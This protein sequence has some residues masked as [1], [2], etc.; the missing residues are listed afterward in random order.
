VENTLEGCFAFFQHDMLDYETIYTLGA[1]AGSKLNAYAQAPL[2]EEL[3]GYLCLYEGFVSI[4]TYE[5]SD[6]KHKDLYGAEGIGNFGDRCWRSLEA[7]AGQCCRQGVGGARR[8]CRGPRGAM[9]PIGGEG[10]L[11]CSIFFS[12]W[13]IMLFIFCF[14]LHIH[15]KYYMYKNFA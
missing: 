15:N 5:A 14:F 3:E 2:M 12:R 7:N 8:G 11:G 1:M 10:K 6:Y 9:W 4:V 13:T